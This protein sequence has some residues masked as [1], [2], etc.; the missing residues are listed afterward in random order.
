MDMQDGWRWCNQCYG[1]AYSTSGRGECG[2]EEGHNFGT[3]GRYLV[4]IGSNPDGTQPGW[5]WCE[6]CQSLAYGEGEAGRCYA[7]GVHSLESSAAYSV[8]MDTVPAGAQEG[9]RWCNRCQVLVFAGGGHGGICPAGTQHDHTGSAAYSV[10]TPAS[11]PV[12]VQPEITVQARPGWISVAGTGF[13]PDGPVHL[14]FLVGGKQVAAD[15]TANSAGR[16]LHGEES[17]IGEGRCMVIV[18]DD[19][20]GRF[21]AAHLERSHP[22]RIPLDPVPID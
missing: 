11:T 14:T 17:R 22:I 2:G 6:R 7:G 18:R 9:W 19:T 12:V 1:L 16:I 4:T 10:P 20:T 8:P 3:S 15:V 13:S 21:T 5:R